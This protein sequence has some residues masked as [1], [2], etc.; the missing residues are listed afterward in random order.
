MQLNLAAS[1]S[2][3]GIGI[4]GEVE[5]STSGGVVYARLMGEGHLPQLC[6]ACPELKGRLDMVKERDGDFTVEMDVYLSIGC[7]TVM[8]SAALSTDGGLRHFVLSATNPMCFLEPLVQLI[9]DYVPGGGLI[10]D[11]LSLSIKKVTFMYD[12]AG[13]AISL[14]IVLGFSD[15]EEDASTL[16]IVSLPWR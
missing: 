16:A 11:M 4:L 13:D 7:F 15:D 5:L 2:F 12:G 14:E 1:M 9:A 10:L 8:G 3:L 6:D